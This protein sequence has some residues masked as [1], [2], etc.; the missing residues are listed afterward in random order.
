M[1]FSIISNKLCQCWNTDY[2]VLGGWSH[3]GLKVQPLRWN[4]STHEGE[5]QD[6]NI[7]IIS[8]VTMLCSQSDLPVNF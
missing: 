2:W 8:S 6:G 7:E 1:I 4:I 3:Q 5:M